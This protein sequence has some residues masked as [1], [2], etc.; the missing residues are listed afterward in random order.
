MNSDITDKDARVEDAGVCHRMGWNFYRMELAFGKQAFTAYNSN[1]APIG[2]RGGLFESSFDELVNTANRQ[3]SNISIPSFISA[4]TYATDGIVLEWVQGQGMY[5]AD[6]FEKELS[7][8]IWGGHEEFETPRPLW[9][10]VRFYKPGNHAQAL[11]A[12]EEERDAQ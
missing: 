1:I 5:Y 3:I 2:D 4:P 9:E 7:A 12:V 10:Y 6:E 8:I 11:L